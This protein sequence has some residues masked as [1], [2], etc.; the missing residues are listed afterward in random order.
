MKIATV[1]LAF[2]LGISSVAS[3]IDYTVDYEPA[4]S[5]GNW[6][7]WGH[8]GA[9]TYSVSTSVQADGS[10]HVYV[11]DAVMSST[12]YLYL[13]LDR[14][15]NLVALDP[16][17]GD[18]HIDLSGKFKF[19][20]VNDSGNTGTVADF[21]AEFGYEINYPPYSLSGM[22]FNPLSLD[23]TITGWQTL[24]D[25]MRPA[26]DVYPALTG[27]GAMS[28][29]ARSEIGDFMPKTRGPSLFLRN[30]S[31]ATV[32]NVYSCA[33]SLHVRIYVDDISEEGSLVPDSGFDATATARAA[34]YKTRVQDDIKAVFDAVDANLQTLDDAVLPS[35]IE[36]RLNS[37]MADIKDDH[38]DLKAAKAARPLGM[39]TV[40]ELA[41][42]ENFRAVTA[43]LIPSIQYIQAHPSQSL[44]FYPWDATG[45][46]RLTGVSLAGNGAP[47]VPLAVK[48]SRNKYEPISFAVQNLFTDDITVQS[49][50]VS[51]LH[52][53]YNDNLPSSAIDVRV[54]KSWYTGAGETTDPQRSSG[55][56]LLPALLLKD[57]SLVQVDRVNSKN[58]LKLTNGTYQDVSAATALMPNG[59]QVEDA[60][61]LQSFVIPSLES[62]QLWLTLDTHGNLVP[63]V[64]TGNIVVNYLKNGVAGQLSIPST[65]DLSPATLGGS[66][67]TYSV[68]YRSQITNTGTGKLGSD[69]KT[70]TQ[71][72]AEIANMLAHGVDH[73]T[74]YIGATTTA[75]V[76]DYLPIRNELGMPCDKVYLLNGIAALN[77]YPATVVGTHTDALVS[78]VRGVDGCESADVYLYGK[79]E[80][81]GDELDA[82][83]DQMKAVRDHGG[84]TFVA[85]YIGTYAKL[86]DRLDTIVYS[87]SAQRPGAATE[88]NLWTGDGHDVFSYGNPQTGIAD[89]YIYRRNYGLYLIQNNFTGAMDYAYQHAMPGLET[90]TG[91]LSGGL[92]RTSTTGYCSAWNNFDSNWA[93]D[94]V[95][96]YP[97]SSGVIDTVQWEGF[98]EGVDDTRYL[99]LLLDLINANNEVPEASDAYFYLWD[100]ID[101]PDFEPAAVRSQMIGYIE[102]ISR[103]VDQAPTI[104][105]TVSPSGS[106][107]HLSGSA[108]DAD[109]DLA[110]IEV[111]IDSGSWQR[112][113]RESPW[114]FDLQNVA[115]GTHTVDYRATDFWGKTTSH[116]QTVAVALCNSAA[117][118]SGCIHGLNASYYNN[119]T[120]TGSP[121]VQRIEGN[122][123]FDWAFASPIPGTVNADNFSV[124]WA[125][126]IVPPVTGAYVFCTTSDDGV[127]LAIDDQPVVARWQDQ[128]AATYCGTVNLTA[129]QALPFSVDYY[130]SGE[131]AVVQV[132][133]S[134]PGQSTQVAVPSSVLYPQ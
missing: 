132:T 97:T 33:R 1:A 50:D 120:L 117:P 39:P 36:T 8:K 96:T 26:I 4:G 70:E 122:V 38:D 92:C 21:A 17:N 2:T 24:G 58:A 22:T 124:G 41:K 87:G 118:V 104:S 69:D 60:T 62:R 74:Q 102:A 18:L 133:W 94:L 11:I 68:Y 28:Y 123:Y 95:F 115:I 130:D 35:A 76:G 3:A 12:G 32:A 64:Y 13:N 106:T 100:F 63:G 110:V 43:N 53:Q 121:V 34:A 89:P 85:G 5:S 112:V 86:S 79:D 65:I 101:D 52:N 44:V 83:R 131:E 49:I 99:K 20:I 31:C 59:A 10:N 23:K 54:V 73:P 127:W 82:E 111:R 15:H 90:T 27:A 19:E 14:A 103:A 105:A 30:N 109:N 91:D 56:A 114:Q 72:R 80:G 84:K 116:Q 16:G 61:T 78:G 129:G 29:F 9:G 6:L 134:Y 71:Y 42:D 81:K 46:A 108:A 66:P 40:A 107:V 48:T 67:H 47:N 51:G 25:D 126:K 55:V 75:L 37:E 113:G 77:D 45:K 88:I 125:G 98:R 128:A 7:A 119:A 57:D 93:Y